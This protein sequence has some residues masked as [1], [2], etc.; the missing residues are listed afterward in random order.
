MPRVL[1]HIIIRKRT[2]PGDSG[3]D[4]GIKRP[5]LGLATDQNILFYYHSYSKNRI[6]E[7]GVKCVKKRQGFFLKKRENGIERTKLHIIVVLSL[8]FH[9]PLHAGQR[10]PSLYQPLYG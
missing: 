5:L 7:L 9:V 2:L 1:T 8:R 3:N 10:M 4:K 6:N